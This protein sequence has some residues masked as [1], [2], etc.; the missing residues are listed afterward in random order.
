MPRAVVPIPLAKP[1]INRTSPTRHSLHL[2]KGLFPALPAFS[3]VLFG[4]ANST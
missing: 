3:A 4:L 1:S 2:E